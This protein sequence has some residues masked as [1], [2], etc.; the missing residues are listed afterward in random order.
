MPL[1]LG[2]EEEPNK[3]PEL[4]FTASARMNTI[5]LR[6][7]IEALGDFWESVR[8]EPGKDEL[9]ITALKDN[10]EAD[11]DSIKSTIP[12]SDPSDVQGSAVCKYSQEYLNKFLK[13]VQK[14]GKDITLSWGEDYPLMLEVVGVDRWSL[15]FIL[16]PRVDND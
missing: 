2:K 10:G 9:I 1:I 15:R 11:D 4:K 6:D 12:A 16:A 5:I 7:E 3:W 13:A 14:C 8:L